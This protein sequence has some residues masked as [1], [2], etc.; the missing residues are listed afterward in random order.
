MRRNDETRHGYEMMD[1]DIDLE[2]C[3]ERNSVVEMKQ[4]KLQK[5]IGKRLGLISKV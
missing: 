3:M 4:T 1:M 5:E 2:V